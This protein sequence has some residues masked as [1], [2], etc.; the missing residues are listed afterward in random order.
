MEKKKKLVPGGKNITFVENGLIYVQIDAVEEDLVV[1]PEP[2]E[3]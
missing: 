1:L 2:S 3:N